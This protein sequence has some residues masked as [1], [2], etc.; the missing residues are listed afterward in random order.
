MDHI[1]GTACR[2]VPVQPLTRSLRPSPANG[3][4]RVFLVRLSLVLLVGRWSIL[5]TSSPSR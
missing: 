3:K 2:P 5:Q 1:P 4:R